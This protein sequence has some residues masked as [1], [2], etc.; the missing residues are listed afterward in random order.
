MRLTGGRRKVAR[1]SEE[2]VGTVVLGAWLGCACL[3]TA[4]NI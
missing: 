4:N 2:R 3:C 1:C